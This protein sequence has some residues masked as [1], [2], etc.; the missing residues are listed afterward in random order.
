MFSPVLRAVPQRCSLISRSRVV[1]VLALLVAGAFSAQA[2]DQTSRY[3][4]FAPSKLRDVPGTANCVQISEV[5]FRFRGAALSMAGVVVTNPGGNTP[6]EEGAS[7][8]ADSNTA[9][10]WLDFNKGALVFTF[11]APVT[12]DS[13]TFATANDSPE[14][15][16]VSWRLE[17]SQDG[18]SWAR[19][20]EV[21]NHAVPTTRLTYQQWFN[22]PASGGVPGD[23][24]SPQWHP[25]E[26]LRWTPDADP[27]APF[28]RSTVPLATRVAPIAALKANPHA[29]LNEGR[30]MPLIAFNSIPAASAQG[31]RTLRYHTPLFW[32]YMHALTFWGGSDRDTR[33]ILAPSA[34]VVDAAHRNGVPVLGKIFF[35]FSSEPQRLAIV[36]SFLV[37]S[38]NTFPVADKLIEAARYFGLEGWFINQETAGTNA[39]D[40][41]NMRDFIKYFRERAP[42][43]EIM[44]YDA[45]V[46]SGARSFQNALTSQN[47]AF[48]KEG[49]GLVSHSIFLNFWWGSGFG[50]TT[51]LPN[52][53]QLALSLGIDP[54]DIY[55]GIDTEGGGFDTT[56]DWNALFPE[57]QPHRLSLGIYRPEWTFNYSNGVTNFHSR[58][59]RYWV[60]ETGDPTNTATA[61]DWKGIAHYIPEASPISTLP[62]VTNF[63]VGQGSRYAVGGATVMVGPWSNLSLQDILP[64]WRWRVESAGTKLT[65]SLDL[66]DAYQGGASLKVAGNLD[67][68]NRIPLYRCDLP[69]SATTNV[70]VAFKRGAPGASAMQVGFAFKDNPTAYTYLNVGAASTSGWNTATL[71]LSN[72]QGKTLVAISLQFSNPTAIPGYTMRVGQLAMYDGAIVTPAPPSN[73]VVD[74]KLSLDAETL[75]LRLK[76]THSTSAVQHYN[77]YL[78]NSDNSR[79]WL[80]ATPNNVYFVPAARRKGKDSSL[81]IE[82]ETVGR[83]FG[84]SNPAQVVVDLPA[85]PT[86]QHRIAGAA[87]GTPGSSQ[88]SGRTKE[89]VFDRNLSTY[90]DAPMADGVWVGQDLGAD[91]ERAI[92]AIRYYPRTGWGARMVGGVFQ[93]SNTADFSSNVV[94][95]AS[96]P[97]LPVEGAFSTIAVDNP[98]RFRYVRYLSPNGGWGNVSEV[99]FYGVPL[100]AAP[101]S[102]AGSMRDGTASLSWS[103]STYASRY[104][105]KRAAT[106]AGPFTIIASGVSGT[107]HADSGLTFDATYFYTVSAINEAG[108]SPDTAAVSVSDRYSQWVTAQGWTPG[109]AGTSF[110][111]DADRDGVANGLE[112]SAPGGLELAVAGPVA[113]IVAELRLDAGVV[114]TAAKTTDLQVW[115]P[116][117]LSIS[118]DQ[119]GVP[120]G[121]TRWFAEDPLGPPSEKRFFRLQLTR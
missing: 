118:P 50:D 79:V 36:R 10:K 101:V 6:A 62:F 2:I 17:T 5:Q 106:S 116:I 35:A 97:L 120:T 64:T 115:T 80:G 113:R 72:Y 47:D 38:G 83:E 85:S 76:W 69:V 52:S 29:R 32:Q 70:R 104:E 84:I 93:A 82:V 95:L 8:A 121:F 59:L 15:D 61:D 102:L 48:M 16:P 114:A 24:V 7:K 86:L 100:P 63:N 9:T 68:A 66:D 91:N 12:I 112:Y 54:Y 88:N 71:G 1:V 37:K 58:E 53:R 67:A 89:M 43:L 51:N 33:T 74:R 28:N 27:D 22:L 81:T 56:V 92:T 105:I 94:T 4:R 108:R 25:D 73:V 78:R 55:A 14:R 23:P 42:E 117:T 26:L 13:Y 30:V 57:G 60:G 46:E 45:M 111:E 87:I 39:T 77:V 11:P 119:T 3:F 110:G 109:S 18:S 90:F 98:T 20:D 40:S 41:Q 96:V 75:S 19:V 44:W 21:N 31:S 107:T 49:L 99:E 65:P 103:P 34:H